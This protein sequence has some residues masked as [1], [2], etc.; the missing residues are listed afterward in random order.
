M[1]MDFMAMMQQQQE[2]SLRGLA[3][4]LRAQQPPVQQQ[5]AG[6]SQ[7]VVTAPVVQMPAVQMPAV[8]MP[9]V[10]TPVDSAGGSQQAEG[11]EEPAK[12]Q[13]KPVKR[14]LDDDEPAKRRRLPDDVEPEEWRSLLKKGTEI[15]VMV[16]VAGTSKPMPYEAVVIG[17]PAFGS[18]EIKVNVRWPLPGTN[19][20]RWPDGAE[21]LE[22]HLYGRADVDCGWWLGWAE[23]PNGRV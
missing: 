1:L 21:T 4:Q 11:T 7:Q 14:F 20:K 12:R 2:A 16:H 17:S 3:E 9:A 18:N 10:Q 23:K 6:S 22:A 15:M 8:Q 19:K 5:V 13:R